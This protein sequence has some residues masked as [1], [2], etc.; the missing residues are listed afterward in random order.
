MGALGQSSVRYEIGIF[1]GEQLCAA[2]YFV[3][4]FVD[5][6]TRKPQP[7]PPAI[8]DSLQRLAGTAELAR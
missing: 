6:A 7:I 8:R 4:V 2:G 1:K 5:R 3:H